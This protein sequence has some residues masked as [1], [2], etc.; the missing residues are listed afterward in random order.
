MKKSSKIL[1]CLKRRED[2]SSKVHTSDGLATGL[3]NSAQFVFNLLKNKKINVEFKVVVDANN[4]D[5][6]VSL[7]KPTHV[8]IEALWVTPAKFIELSKL[9]PSVTWIVRLHS[10]IPFIANEGMAMG[11]IGDY[12]NIPNV[13]IACNSDYSL[14]DIRNYLQIK[15][16]WNKK[17]LEDKVIFLPNYYVMDFKGKRKK[18]K[19]DYIDIGCFGAVRP[20]KN[21]LTQALAAIDFAEKNN[22]KLRFHI[23]DGRVE[24]KGEP[25]INNLKALFVHMSD[26]GHYMIMHDWLSREDFLNLCAEMDIGLQVSF[27]E[28]FNIVGADMINAGTPLVASNELP[29][30]IKEYC[31][32]PV[33]IKNI[34]KK[35]KQAYISPRLNVLLHKIALWYYTNKVKN[36]WLEQFK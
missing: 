31:G 29:W 16:K 32:N 36:V 12:S 21:H 24:Q 23:N 22:K 34:S 10:E 11:W 27:S 25:V 5:R 8:I 20:L 2:Y 26:R 3:Y 15:N 19:N 17:T 33:D 28:T 1:F 18:E 30:T 6:E 14:R 7:Y 9:H 35:I 4:I 13:V